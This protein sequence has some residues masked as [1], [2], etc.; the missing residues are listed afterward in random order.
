M[1]SEGKASSLM[2]HCASYQRCKIPACARLC[3]RAHQTVPNWSCEHR[4]VSCLMHLILKWI[5][6]FLSHTRWVRKEKKSETLILLILPFLCSKS[7]CVPI[8]IFN[9]FRC[10]EGHCIHSSNLHTETFPIHVH[11]DYITK[12]KTTMAT[13]VECTFQLGQIDNN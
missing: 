1:C 13:L 10:S 3:V 7:P 2:C 8:V 9:I 4:E 12:T 11:V 6:N 5:F